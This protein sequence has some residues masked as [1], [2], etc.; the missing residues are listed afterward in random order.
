[1]HR[2][3]F[4]S[5]RI[6]GKRTTLAGLCD[7]LP[8]FCTYSRE[9]PLYGSRAALMRRLQGGMAAENA[10]VFTGEEGLCI[11]R[12]DS[13]VRVQACAQPGFVR[14]TAEAMN[15][16]IAAELC[17]FMETRTRKLDASR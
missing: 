3:A 5:S 11:E 9:L 15:E 12:P 1:M 8:R 7:A 13:F 14:I 16:E 4:L 6:A 10:G 17:D 2:A